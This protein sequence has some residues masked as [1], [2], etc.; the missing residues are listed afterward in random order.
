MSASPKI[1]PGWVRL[2]TGAVVRHGDKMR[3]YGKWVELKHEGDLSGLVRAGE[4]IIRRR[5]SKG[6]TP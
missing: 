3:T 4:L 2:Q 5:P 6:D 1:P